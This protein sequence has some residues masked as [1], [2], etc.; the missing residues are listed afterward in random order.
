[1][2]KDTALLAKYRYTEGY[3][4]EV[5]SQL[6]GTGDRDYWLCNGNSENKLFMFSSR[7]QNLN[8]EER[9]I[10]GEILDAIRRYEGMPGH[11]KYGGNRSLS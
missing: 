3:Y 6:P 5:V 11:G 2:E 8:C 9:L 7:Y 1:M 4:V 10:A